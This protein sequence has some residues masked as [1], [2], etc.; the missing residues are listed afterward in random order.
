MSKF[1]ELTIVEEYK[2]FIEENFPG[3]NLRNEHNKIIKEVFKSID[4]IE[5]YANILREDK[6]SDLLENLKHQLFL[7]AFNLPKYN[8]FVFSSIIRNMSETVLRLAIIN[9]VQDFDKLLTLNYQCL[10]KNIKDSDYYNDAKFAT[11]IGKFFS[12][13]GKE[14]QELHRTTNG[15]S[16]INFLEELN[17]TISIR[18]SDQLVRFLA[19]LDE[20]ILGHFSVQE[21]INDLTLELSNKISLKS[22]IT[23]QIYDNY[24]KK[25]SPAL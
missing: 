20:F 11:L 1:K 10:K 8:N 9:L 22:I 24:F 3:S 18:K 14:S 21:N 6:S 17:V 19:N 23:Q 7:V 4:I 25:T 5:V 15:S 12:S 16:K 2:I 13:F